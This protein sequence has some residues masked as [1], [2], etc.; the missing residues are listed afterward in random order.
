MLD[1]IKKGKYNMKYNVL[2]I[3]Y[4]FVEVEANSESE[5]L[6]KVKGYG[7]EDITWSD[8]FEADVAQEEEDS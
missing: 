5:A 4:G 1:I 6:T 7:E 3:R 8:N 2:F